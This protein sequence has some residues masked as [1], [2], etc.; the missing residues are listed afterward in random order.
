GNV[1]L[2][3]EL[4]F[5]NPL[6]HL[7][8]QRILE[9]VTLRRAPGSR[10]LPPP[11]SLALELVHDLL[12]GL[13]ALHALRLVHNDVKLSNFLVGIDHASP[14]IDDRSYFHAL[15]DGL[16]HGVLIDGGGVRTLE[17]LER[18]NAGDESVPP[19]ELT[20]L[21]AP[22][23]A[24]LG[25]TGEASER[26]HHGTA[27]DVYAAA[28]VA[29]TMLTGYVPYQHLRRQIV[30]TDLAQVLDL[31]R[32]ERRGDVGPIDRE[33]LRQARFQDSRFADT[34]HRGHEVCRSHFE[35]DLA[36]LLLRRVS[37][38]LE[39]R[40]S[41]TDMKWEFER[42]FSIHARPRTLLKTAA[43]IGER[44]PRTYEQHL[45]LVIKGD[46]HARLTEAAGPEQPAGHSQ[47]ATPTRPTR[48]LGSLWGESRDDD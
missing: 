19:I 28:L 43:K 8:E 42:A 5:P 22:P 47:R 15:E 27:T 3:F 35:R 45:F 38:D 34:E 7:N 41:A 6:L 14:E 37:P 48:N 26:P 44:G 20:P 32:A 4:L 40:G 31:K 16:F 11:P 33:H 25:L 17:A 30:A 1:A 12:R 18:L 9:R 39:E 36:Q 2:I 21:Y 46:P 10:Y 23:E 13:E 29:F 24:L